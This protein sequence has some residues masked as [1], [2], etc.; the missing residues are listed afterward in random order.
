LN[1]LIPQ[2]D[3]AVVTPGIYHQADRTHLLQAIDITT[4]LTL[5]D[6]QCT[7]YDAAERVLNF[8]YDLTLVGNE[9]KALDF[10]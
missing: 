7:V 10:G 8:R 5:A 6:P 2:S 9:A 1:I 3:I 4:R